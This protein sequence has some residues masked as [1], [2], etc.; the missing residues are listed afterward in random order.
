MP[1]RRRGS[2]RTTRW[3][4]SRLYNKRPAISKGA[5]AKAEAKAGH[6]QPAEH[7]GECEYERSFNDSAVRSA[8]PRVTADNHTTAL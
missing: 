5:A 7:R 1:Y 6:A 3:A 8:T 4:R 2:S